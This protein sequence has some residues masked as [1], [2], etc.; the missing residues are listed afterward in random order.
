MGKFCTGAVGIGI[1]GAIIGMHIYM[2]L[3]PRDQRQ[4][5]RGLKNAV[6]D[7]KNIT[8]KLTEVV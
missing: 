8:E 4:I 7:L 2:F 3:S 1:A 5:H 6:D